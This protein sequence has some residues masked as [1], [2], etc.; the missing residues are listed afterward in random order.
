MVIDLINAIKTRLESL[1]EFQDAVVSVAIN[2]RFQAQPQGLLEI[3]VSPLAVRYERETRD[4]MKETTIVSVSLSKYFADVFDEHDPYDLLK[5]TTAVETALM[6]QDY[7][8]NGADYRW[9]TSYASGDPFSDARQTTIGGM[10]DVQAV[11]NAFTL[12]APV[13]VQFMRMLKIGP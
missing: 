5:L 3:V 13:V 10:F 7:S 9:E 6:M 8:V 11:D 12:Q 1:D 4:L 2:P